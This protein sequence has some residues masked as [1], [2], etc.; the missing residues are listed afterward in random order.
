MEDAAYYTIL[1]ILEAAILYF[2]LLNLNIFFFAE[3]RIF[4]DTKVETLIVE[5]RQKR[6]QLL[7]SGV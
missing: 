2:K 4:F 1:Y 3:M 6:K 7:R 5:G